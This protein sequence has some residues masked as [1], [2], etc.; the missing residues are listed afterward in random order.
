M[1]RCA[2][3]LENISASNC[4]GLYGMVT[5]VWLD[6]VE[7]TVTDTNALLQATWEGF[8][9]AAPNSR[10]YIAVPTSDDAERTKEDANVRVGNTG[11]RRKTAEGKLDFK[12]RIGNLTICQAKKLKSLD[13]QKM[14]AWFLTLNEDILCSG[15]DA[16]NKPI[17]VDIYVDDYTTAETETEMGYVIVHVM[18]IPRTNYFTKAVS[19]FAQSTNA[20]RPSDLNGLIDVELSVF[21]NTAAAVVT[22]VV[23]ACDGAEINDIVTAGDFVIENVSTG[24]TQNPTTIAAAG[25]RY[26]LGGLTLVNATDYYI[27]LKSANLQTDKKYET[28]K[29][30]NVYKLSFTAVV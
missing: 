14:Y 22:D 27:Y 10:L 5:G 28:N 6:Q 29:N 2:V 15:T 8:I 25:N 3:N 26:T 17:P 20:W 16:N 1:E 11:K 19:P 24:A 4:Q 18:V 23:S 9:A 12:F 7:R 21:S 13:G 30:G